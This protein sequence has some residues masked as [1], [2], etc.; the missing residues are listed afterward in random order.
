MTGQ[1]TARPART[2]TWRVRL[3]IF[4]EDDDATTVHATLD[5]GEMLGAIQNRDGFATPD[6]D[7]RG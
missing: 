6:G 5:T 3:D 4:E 1:E 2:K 7:V